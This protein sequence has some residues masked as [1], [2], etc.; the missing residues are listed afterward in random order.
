MMFLQQF[1]QIRRGTGF[2]PIIIDLPIFKSIKQTERVIHANGF[3]SKMIAIIILF[4]FYTEFLIRQTLGFCKF[5][6]LNLQIV[7][8]FFITNATDFNI[9]FPHRNIVQVIQVTEYAYLAKLR[10][11][12]QHS[13]SDTAIHRLE[14][15]V[16][17][18][19]RVTVFSLQG[20]IADSLQQRFVVFVYKDDDTLACQLAGTVYNPFETQGKS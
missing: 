6:K 2:E 12:C 10:D 15:A 7:M 13:K 17:R 14:H 4:Q 5:M 11:T 16:K 9:F 8:D 1:H 20:F 18:F 19:Q 3:V